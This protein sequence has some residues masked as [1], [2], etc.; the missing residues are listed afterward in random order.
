MA[1]S[2][3]LR[4]VERNRKRMR[5]KGISRFE[6]RALEGDKALVKAFA[7]QLAADDAGAQSLREEFQRR[8]AERSEKR[9]TL[10][11]WFRRSP[12]LGSGVKFKHEKTFGRKIDL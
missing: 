1:K 6:G 4:A 9:G 10:A 2:A 12:L 8:L 5:D 11:E 7:K 3:Q